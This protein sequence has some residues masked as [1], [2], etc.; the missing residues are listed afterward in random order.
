MVDAE[1]DGLLLTVPILERMRQ[2]E[3][4]LEDDE[5]DLLIAV[6]ARA[7]AAPGERPAVV[8]VGSYCGRSTVVL[9]SVVRAVRPEARVYAIDPH[10]G[11]VVGRVDRG[12]DA[13]VAGALHCLSQVAKLPPVHL[14]RRH[15]DDHVTPDREAAQTTCF[16][17]RGPLF[18]GSEYADPP[19]VGVGAC[20][21]RL[22]RLFLRA[23]HAERI[24]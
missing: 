24:P 2:V 3:G 20:D 11:Q 5:A 22:D 14:E 1:P 13:G 6:T 10:Q 8:E 12:G 18:A 19:A 21:E 15:I 7:L 4:W 17:P 23:R 16:P 9:G